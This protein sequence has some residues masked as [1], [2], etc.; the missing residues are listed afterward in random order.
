MRPVVL[1][2]LVLTVLSL[3][4]GSDEP[5]TTA[6]PVRSV[7]SWYF[8]P[9]VCGLGCPGQANCCPGLT[10]V[11]VDRSVMPPR[12]KLPVGALTSLRAKPFDTCVPQGP[13][14]NVIAWTASDPSILRFDPSGSG[15]VIVTALAVGVSRV[16]AER[17]LPDG[18]T[19]V[20]GL[21]DPYRLETACTP[22]PEFLFEV[23]P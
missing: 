12:V 7:D 15:S 17:L 6:P 21:S 18:T 4:C 14:V 16:T 22:E 10:N 1:V 9:L 19:S 13:D 20:A 2:S 8:Y 23:V 5:T 3:S 11:E